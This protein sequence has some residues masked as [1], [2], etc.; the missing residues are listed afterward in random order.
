[1]MNLAEYRRPHR[2]ARRLSCPGRRWS[3]P[4]S[5]STRTAVSSARRDSAAP[6]STARRR[7]SWSRVAGAAQQRA[8]AA[9][10][11]AGRSSS[12]RSGIRG[13]DLSA[14]A[15]FPIPPRRWSTPSA[16]P[17]SRRPAPISRSSYFLTFLC[18][19]PAED[20]ARTEALALRGARRNRASIPARSLRG[21]I[22]RTDRVLAAPRRL[23]AGMPPG[24]M[25]PRR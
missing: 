1:M 17:T 2:P 19:P 23:H 8:S 9:S 12:R 25:T 4:A 10:A 15:R 20:A 14:T 22:D 24:S 13:R 6:I 5:C 16:R 18:L 3:R 7:P 11:P 21:F